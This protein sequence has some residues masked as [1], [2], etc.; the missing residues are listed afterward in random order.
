MY[1]NKETFQKVLSVC[2]RH[3][4]PCEQAGRN[5]GFSGDLVAGLPGSAPRPKSARD[6]GL[7]EVG[8]F[9]AR[10]KRENSRNSKFG[11]FP[12][13]AAAGWRPD[14]RPVV[15][16]SAH[17]HYS[18]RQVRRAR[19]ARPAGAASSACAAR[20]CVRERPCA[21]NGRRERGRGRGAGGRTRARAG[22][23]H[24]TLPARLPPPL[25]TRT[26]PHP[27][28]PRRRGTPPP[29]HAARPETAAA[30]AAPR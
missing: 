12:H 17:A 27:T 18:V 1:N 24:R 10:Q 13:V 5:C 26:P 29:L 2:R 21:Q 8:L 16:V 30:A 6:P 14:D 25:P 22:G 9:C 15:F 20:T 3:T 23:T 28:P 4:G 11:A 19:R 7:P